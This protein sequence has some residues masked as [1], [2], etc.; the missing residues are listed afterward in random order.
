M[1]FNIVR[2][3]TTLVSNSTLLYYIYMQ[4]EATMTFFE[5]IFHS[6]LFEI[7]AV[8]LSTVAVLMIGS[9]NVG[10]AIGTGVIMAII[11][12]LSCYY[13]VNGAFTRTLPS[14][15]ARNNRFIAVK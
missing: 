13:I 12:M 9:V 3:R 8:S 4:G 15:M 11:A 6:I 2:R 10:A 5:R 7:G 1:H 14:D